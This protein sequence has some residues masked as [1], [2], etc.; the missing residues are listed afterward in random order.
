MEKDSELRGWKAH[1]VELQDQVYRLESEVAQLKSAAEDAAI[2]IDGEIKY[3]DMQRAEVARLKSVIN[4]LEPVGSFT[5]KFYG[6]ATGGL[7]FEV[8]CFDALPKVGGKLY[9]SPIPAQQSQVVTGLRIRGDEMTVNHVSC[10]E[11]QSPAAPEDVPADCLSP[12]VARSRRYGQPAQQSQAVAAHDDTTWIIEKLSYHKF[13]RDDLSIDDCLKYLSSEWTEVAGR[14]TRQLVMQILSM[15]AGQQSPAVAIPKTE[16]TI[17]EQDAR[18]IATQFFYWW[19]NQPGKNTM[20]GFS[21]WIAVDGRDL[22]NKLNEAK[23][24]GN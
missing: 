16:N 6:G 10:A 8:K 21:E 15:L 14:T 3:C 2:A 5:G 22:L 18:E 20:Q 19:H 24:H 13:E 9:A 17:T 1:C 11:Q 4:E 23:N 7:Y 12:T